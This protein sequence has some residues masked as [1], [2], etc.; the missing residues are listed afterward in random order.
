MFYGLIGLYGVYLIF[1]GI[2]SNSKNLGTSIQKD[3]PGFFPWL[4]ALYVMYFFYKNEKT[5]KFGV[6]FAWLVGI[7]FVV[8]NFDTIKNELNKIKNNIQQVSP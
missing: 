1:V 5:H 7:G 6:A 3:A 2:K 8:K 4:V